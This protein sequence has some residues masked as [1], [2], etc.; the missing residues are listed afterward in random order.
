MLILLERKRP[1]QI[2]VARR[3]ILMTN[4]V[5]EEGM[6]LIGQVTQQAAYAEQ[7]KLADSI[8]R[9]G[10]LLAEEAE[11]AEEMRIAAQF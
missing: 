4:E 9:R 6:P 11:P 3:E 10:I 8:V 1:G 5:G 7:V 2:V